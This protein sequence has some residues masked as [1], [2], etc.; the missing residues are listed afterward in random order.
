GDG[1][2]IGVVAEPGTGK[3]RLCYEFSQQCR[4]RGIRVH[5]GHGVAHGKMIPFLPVLELLRGYF[6]ITEEDSD[7]DA[8]E[9]ITDELPLD[10]AFQDALPLLFEFLGVPDPQRPAPRMDPEARQRQLFDALCR[11]THA[12]SQREPAV[13]LLE[14]LHWIDGGS[15]A[16]LENMVA[17]LPPT[18]A[19]VV[20][21]F[22][23]E[24][25]G[26][27]TQRSYYRQLPLLPLGEAAISEM[28]TQ[29]LGDDRSLA[30]LAA[31]IRE[32][33]RGNPFFIEEVVQ[34]L[35][36]SGT[37]SGVKG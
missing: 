21:N 13:I 30:G 35:V 25:H 34:S 28:L 6:G 2:I 36:E 23:P 17:P 15:E 24:C 4:A 14:D 37:L 29:L 1:Q 33:T 32:R 27:W 11:L 19:L 26:G 3:S 8:R 20:V 16:F 22:R 12:R 31:Q 5:E 18:P 9:K 7:H 10:Q